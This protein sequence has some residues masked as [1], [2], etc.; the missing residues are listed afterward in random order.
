MSD[1]MALGT[2]TATWQ[3]I[4]PPTI[5]IDDFFAIDRWRADAL[6]QFDL[7]PQAAG[8]FGAELSE[9]WPALLSSLKTLLE[10]GS[11]LGTS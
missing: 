11:T 5:P 9:G 8:F 10:T 3:A 4:E 7:D 2:M 6:R 1:G